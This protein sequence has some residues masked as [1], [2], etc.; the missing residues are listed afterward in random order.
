LKARQALELSASEVKEYR[1]RRQGFGLAT[2]LITILVVALY[3][4]IRQM[5]GR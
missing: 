4:K 2:I 3:L 1:F 5:E